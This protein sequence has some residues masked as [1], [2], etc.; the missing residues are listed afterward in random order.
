M[1]LPHLRS[2]VEKGVEVVINFRRRQD[3][4]KIGDRVQRT[5]T[6]LGNT[7]PS[8]AIACRRSGSKGVPRNYLSIRSER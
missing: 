5:V 2:S 4:Q 3:R 8:L 6:P 7:P 1:R